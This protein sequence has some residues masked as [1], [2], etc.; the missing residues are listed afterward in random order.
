MKTTRIQ[1]VDRISGLPE[2]ILH[3]ILSFLSFREAAQTCVLSKTWDRTWHRYPVFKIDNGYFYS[4]YHYKDSVFRGRRLKLLGS[5]EKSLR[6]RHRHC[7]DLVSMEKFNMVV[8]LFEDREFASFVDRCVS[9]A[10]GCNVKKLR[11]DFATEHYDY[12]EGDRGKRWYNLPPIVLCAK[13]IEVL[14]LGRCKLEL[15][16]RND[17]KLSHLRKL[18]LHEIDINNHVISNLFAGCPLIEEVIVGKCQ[19]FDSIELFG[20]GRIIGIMMFDNWG[21]KRVDAKVLNVS[22][23]TIVQHD[24]IIPFDINILYCTNLENIKLVGASITDEWLYKLTSELP[25]LE[26]LYLGSC[27]K[28]K[29]IKISNPSLDTLQISEC[30][31]V[32]ELE[33]DSPNLSDFTYDGGMISFCS[34]ALA[35]SNIDLYFNSIKLDTQWNVKLV[36]LLSQFHSF[37]EMLKLKVSKDEDFDVPKELRQML[38][39]PLSSGKHFQLVINKVC[40]PFSIAKVVDDLLSVA[41]HTETISIDYYY[42][43]G[44]SKNFFEF[45]YKKPLVNEGEPSPCFKSLPISCW[46]HC[47]EEVKLEIFNSDSID[48]KMCSLRGAEFL[49]KVDGLCALK[50]C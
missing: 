33:I 29:R 9:Y 7:K 13:S 14:K 24:A 31:K 47:I 6:N 19:G 37:S 5:L 15:P 50:K 34:N 22:S 26:S 1:E 36:E 17:A 48:E 10:I 18:H 20:L 41:P 38:P 44:W 30:V 25:F 39:S 2:P 49:E 32:V 45:S 12:D 23:L 21:F 42:S 28:L 16:I 27:H 3:H 35:L 40:L 4:C 8:D 43:H 46:Q 11:L